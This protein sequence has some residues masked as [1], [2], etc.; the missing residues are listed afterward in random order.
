LDS[1]SYADEGT[2]H[3]VASNGGVQVSSDP[4]TVTMNLGARMRLK[5]LSVRNKAAR[6][7]QTLMMGFA[8]GGAGPLPLLIRGVGPGLANFGVPSVASDPSITIYDAGQSVLD[9][10][11]NWVTSTETT[12]TFSRLGAFAL[13]E[14]S[15][16]AVV[17]REF[18]PG[19]NST[20]V[21]PGNGSEGTVVIEAYDAVVTEGAAQLSNLSARTEVG[22]GNEVL[23]AGF[24]LSGDGEKRL[25]I[26]GVGPTLANYGLPVASLLGNPQLE[27]HQ[28]TNLVAA[29]NDWG[30]TADLRT[31]FQTVGAF[32]LPTD[33]SQD[34]ALVVSL[35]AGVYTATVSGADG[36]TG[37][38]L[39]EIYELP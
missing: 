28:G 36:G 22:T 34:A 21:T 18:I 38:A 12:A 31:A 23:I 8:V 3:V 6:G 29:N 10:N 7:D 17:I 39:V 25:L 20:H 1:S 5:N 4:F 15:G 11:D 19:A 24:V 2:Y 16:D 33:T 35:P 9:A 32:D 13:T 37:V 14:G 30:G 27:I 26:R